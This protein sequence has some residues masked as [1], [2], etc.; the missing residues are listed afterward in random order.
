MPEFLSLKKTNKFLSLGNHFFFS[1]YITTCF[2]LSSSGNRIIPKSV[3]DVS[4]DT[5]KKIWKAWV[6]AELFNNS[7]RVSVFQKFPDLLEM[8][9]LIRCLFYSKSIKGEAACCHR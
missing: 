8:N 4:P 7:Y 2:T 5:I 1:G 6:F 9:A 3:S